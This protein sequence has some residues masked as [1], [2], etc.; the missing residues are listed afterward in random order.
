MTRVRWTL[1]IIL[2]LSIAAIA[3]GQF[4][5]RYGQRFGQRYGFGLQQNEP[6][7]T[8][9]VFARWACA[10]GRGWAHDYP[11]AEE[12]F[13][14]IMKEATGINV[15]R[16][17]YL[18]VPMSSNELF[19][20]PFG[21]ISEP[22]MMWLTDQEVV[23]FREF[24]DRGGF[25]MLDDFDGPQQWSVMR[26]N[27][28][29]VFPDSPIVPIDIKH[30]IF[31]TYYD[32]DALYLESPYEVRDRASFWAILDKKGEIAVIVCFNNDV[33]DFWEWIDQPM[34]PLKPS[35]EA[36]RLGINFTLY[37]MSH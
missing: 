29:R 35:A 37:A 2:I 11:D 32:I 13:N 15:D 7:D 16:L 17:S 25:V 19:K 27:I 24:V 3:F 36:L 12:H 22:G 10:N 33:G 26:Q 6:S 5:Q 1:A 31:H 8:E 18:I 4:G 28:Q 9:Y 34:Y 30:P 23:N 20:Y 21:Y 14:Q